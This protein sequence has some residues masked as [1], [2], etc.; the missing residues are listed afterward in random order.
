M[1]LGVW[2]AV[3]LFLGFP[4]GWDKIL[5]VLTGVIIT[6]ISYKSLSRDTGGATNPTGKSNVSM[7]KDVPY[8]EYRAGE[9]NK[10]NP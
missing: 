4:T 5:A 3:F 2:V 1:I 9:I 6:G 8:V 10:I 7:N